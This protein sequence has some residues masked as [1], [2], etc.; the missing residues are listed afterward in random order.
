MYSLVSSNKN[1]KHVTACP[2]LE[3]VGIV[4]WWLAVEA[5]DG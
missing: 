4:D 2:E 5:I 1:T 3:L